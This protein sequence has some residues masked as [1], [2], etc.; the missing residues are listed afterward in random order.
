M[1]GFKV[2]AKEVDQACAGLIKDLK[3]RDMLKDTLV[4]FASEFG[5]TCYSQGRISKSTGEYGREHHRD[6]F[7]AWMAGGGVKPGIAY[8]STD[9]FG[10]Q[11]AEKPVH[12]NDFHATLLHL[13]GINHERLTYA[14]QG[15]NFRLT[16]VGGKVVKELLA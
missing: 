12:V 6:C 11:I 2:G 4:V 13:L 14:F 9:E 3:Q 7:T 16:D 15:R 1:G 10:Y 8:G 5:R